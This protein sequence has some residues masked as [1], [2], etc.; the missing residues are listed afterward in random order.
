MVIRSAIAAGLALVSTLALASQLGINANPDIPQDQLDLIESIKIDTEAA[1]KS[2]MS[3]HDFDWAAED[4]KTAQLAEVAVVKKEE[5]SKVKRIESGPEKTFVIYVSWSLGEGF[6]KGLL[7]ENKDQGNVVLKFRGI[8]EGLTMMQALTKMQRL[9]HETKSPVHV[10]IDPVS[11]TDNGV[12]MVPMVAMYEGGK[13]VSIA[14]G[15][16]S[17]EVFSSKPGVADL[18]VVGDQEE[19]A[20]V[21]MIELMK[22]RASKINFAEKKDKAVKRFWANQAF[23]DLPPALEPRVRKIDPTIVIPADMVAPDGTMIHKAGTRINPLDIRPFTQ[24]LVI[25]DPSIGDQLALARDQ[26]GR[27]GQNQLVTII[28]TSVDRADGWDQLKEIERSLGQ[29]AY[30][31]PVEV[32]ERFDLEHTPSVVTADRKDFYIEEFAGSLSSDRVGVSN[33]P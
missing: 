5:G 29:P 17:T 3:V 19:I 2:G 11:F 30:I 21:D 15:T 9:S 10:E 28:L 6:I 23:I 25:I 7:E 20:E 14:R 18:G 12:Q 8:P 4:E 27:F 32:R 22:D 13:V 31:L 33:N 26:I 16:A 24:R 1:Y